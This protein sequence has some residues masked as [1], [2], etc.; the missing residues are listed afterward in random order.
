M[1]N[2]QL[3]FN[4]ETSDEKALRFA[5]VALGIACLVSFGVFGIIVN[6]I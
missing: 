5:R 6:Q 2:T 3:K 1:K 4:L